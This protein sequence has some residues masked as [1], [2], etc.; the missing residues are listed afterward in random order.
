V[1]GVTAKDF[2]QEAYSCRKTDVRNSCRTEPPT[3]SCL[4]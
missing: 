2:R 4:K 3:I 1:L